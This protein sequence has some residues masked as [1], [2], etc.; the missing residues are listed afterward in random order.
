MVELIANTTTR[1]GLSIEAELDAADYPVGVKVGDD[2]LAAVRIRRS[3]FHGDWNYVILP[4][5]KTL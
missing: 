5:K 2:E 4:N 3:S 1:K